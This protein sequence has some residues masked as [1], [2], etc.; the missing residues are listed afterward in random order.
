MNVTVEFEPTVDELERGVRTGQRR[1]RRAFWIV[2]AVLVVLGFALW[3]LD[4]GGDGSLRI[5]IR[6][7]PF[8]LAL[9]FTYQ[10]LFL[11]KRSVRKVADRLCRPTRITFT[12]EG[13]RYETDLVKSEIGWGSFAKLEETPEFFILHVVKNQM[14]VVPKRAFGPEQAA[15]V[16]AFLTARDP[17]HVHAPVQGAQAGPGRSDP[18]ERGPAAGTAQ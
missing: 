10:L 8:A 16:G 15:E 3:P 9:G 12:D 13:F 14:H 7:W 6:I 5:A 18:E 2:I 4:P 1:R 17:A 11:T